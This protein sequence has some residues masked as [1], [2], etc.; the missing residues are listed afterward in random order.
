MCWKKH[1][2]K[3]QFQA[4]LEK[5]VRRNIMKAK[6]TFSHWENYRIPPSLS[7]PE[8]VRLLV[9]LLWYL[10][11][12]TLSVLVSSLH[13][14][15]RLIQ[16]PS[17]W[18][19]WA[20]FVW[21]YSQGLSF[22][23]FLFWASPVWQ[24][25]LTKCDAAK[26]PRASALNGAL[27]EQTIWRCKFWEFKHKCRCLRM[28]LSAR[29]KKRSHEKRLVCGLHSMSVSEIVRLHLR[30]LHWRKMCLVI[31]VSFVQTVGSRVTTTIFFLCSVFYRWFYPQELF[32]F[33]HRKG[34][35]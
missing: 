2:R 34:L 17:H 21:R 9:I 8:P 31:E 15:L 7:G 28:V 22:W 20:H 14:F 4:N 1:F 29:E 25:G 24:K 33:Q 18:Y 30:L 16:T 26:T 23:R 19:F 13:K 12:Y 35:L 27:S 11:P 5:G 32:S 10:H 3:T 6:Q